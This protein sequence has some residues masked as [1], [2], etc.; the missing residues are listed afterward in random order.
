MENVNREKLSVSDSGV[1]RPGKHGAAWSQ[2]AGMEVPGRKVE[3]RH[4][5]WG[6][7]RSTDTH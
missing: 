4:R 1:S 3:M 6:K 7:V 5:I 2:A